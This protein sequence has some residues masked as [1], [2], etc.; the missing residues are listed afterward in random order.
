M[1]NYSPQLL[2][3]S[4]AVLENSKLDSKRAVSQFF[5]V[6]ADMGKMSGP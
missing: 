1:R 2:G 4:D 3:S 5:L 6:K